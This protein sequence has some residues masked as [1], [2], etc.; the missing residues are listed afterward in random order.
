MSPRGNERGKYTVAEPVKS[1]GTCFWYDENKERHT[2]LCWAPVAQA[3]EDFVEDS[4]VPM[5][6][7]QGRDCDAW[8]P[9]DLPRGILEALQQLD[10][11]G[12]LLREAIRMARRDRVSGWG[13]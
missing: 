11:K 7:E 4:S 5:R 9:C 13:E 6:A 1:C 10:F 3:F 2:G 12:A 8:L